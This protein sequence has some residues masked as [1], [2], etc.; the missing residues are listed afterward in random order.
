[1]GVLAF[2]LLLGSTNGLVTK[3]KQFLVVLACVFLQ[4]FTT[5]LLGVI[6]QVR[7]YVGEWLTQDVLKVVLLECMVL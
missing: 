6:V 3:Q 4:V 2:D 1:M 7:F 5:L